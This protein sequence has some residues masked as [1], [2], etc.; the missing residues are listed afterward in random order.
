MFAFSHLKEIHFIMRIIIFNGSREGIVSRSCKVVLGN[1]FLLWKYF[2]NLRIFKE[3]HFTWQEMTSSYCLFAVRIEGV[4][5][6]VTF[7][8]IFMT[9]KSNSLAMSGSK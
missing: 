3:F 6:N 8:R 2:E 4:Q 7:Y 5:Y 1:D 9:S